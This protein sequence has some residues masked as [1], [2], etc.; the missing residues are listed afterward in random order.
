M[1]TDPGNLPEVIDA[2]DVSAL[3]INE[4]GQGVPSLE[5]SEVSGDLDQFIANT[6]GLDRPDVGGEV[7]QVLTPLDAGPN[8]FSVSIINIDTNGDGAGDLSLI[9]I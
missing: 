6:Q 7:V 2:I 4:M 5:L 8:Q 3:P 9:H 1:V